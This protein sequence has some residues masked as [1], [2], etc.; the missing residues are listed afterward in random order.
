LAFSALNNYSP[1]N[2]VKI[3]TNSSARNFVEEKYEKTLSQ[4]SDERM[5]R[6]EARVFQAC[7]AGLLKIPDDAKEIRRHPVYRL[8]N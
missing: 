7:L 2:L 8:E 6:E 5:G 4:L 1:T 3:E